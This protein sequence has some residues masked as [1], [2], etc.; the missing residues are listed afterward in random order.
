M[1]YQ[2]GITAVKNI[3]TRKKVREVISLTTIKKME[4]QTKLLIYTEAYIMATS[5]MEGVYGIPRDTISIKNELQQVL[6]LVGKIRIFDEIKKNSTY[7]Y[8]RRVVF[9]VN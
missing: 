9:L 8:Y 5:K 4:R 7:K 3:Y 6:H 2:W 1:K